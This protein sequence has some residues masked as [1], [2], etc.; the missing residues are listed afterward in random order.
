MG[1]LKGSWLRSFALKAESAMM[2]RFDVASSISNAMV[3]RLRSKNVCASRARLFPNWVNVDTIRPLGRVSHYR[4]EFNISAHD[5]VVLYSGTLGS[6]HGLRIIPEVAQLLAHRTD[7]VFVICGDGVMKAEL[8]ART[9]EMPNVR[10]LPLQ[11]LERLNEL[12]GMAD[13]HVLPQSAEAEDL[14]LPSKITGMLSS[15]RPVIATC[16]PHSEIARVLSQCGVVTPPGDAM[17]MAAAVAGLSDANE[18]RLTMGQRARCYAED[19]LSIDG[20]LS[21]FARDAAGLIATGEAPPSPPG[22]VVD[23]HSVFSAVSRDAVKLNK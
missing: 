18:Q 6:K 13:I 2:R 21:R 19:N 1:F 16:A 22:L 12:L 3:D 11:P 20:I 23:D 10:M 14:V 17:A 7:I 8:E 15:G 4:A 5:K 9:R